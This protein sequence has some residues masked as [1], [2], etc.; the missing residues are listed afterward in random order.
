MNWPGML[1]G[2]LGVSLSR[3]LAGCSECFVGESSQTP[4][5]HSNLAALSLNRFRQLTHHSMEDSF[6]SG[7]T[8]IHDKKK[9]RFHSHRRSAGKTNS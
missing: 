2:L 7:L 1:E 8:R 9:S 6:L 5:L 3:D 4:P